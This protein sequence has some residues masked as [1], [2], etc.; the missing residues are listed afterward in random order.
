MGGADSN[1]DSIGSEVVS[2]KSKVDT[3]TDTP[4]PEKKKKRPEKKKTIKSEASQ[5]SEN[6]QGRSMLNS[7]CILCVRLPVSELFRSLLNNRKSHE[8][9]TIF[10]MSILS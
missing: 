9:L 7:T 6:I 10:P 1:D 3:N 8:M 2:I 4:K 5:K